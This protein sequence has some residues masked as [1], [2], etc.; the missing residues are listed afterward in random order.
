MYYAH[1]QRAL[2]MPACAREP[3]IIGQNLCGFDTLGLSKAKAFDLHNSISEPG[4]TENRTKAPQI[5]KKAKIVLDIPELVSHI[6]IERE[7]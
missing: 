5:P 2:V 7:A 6:R 4:S 1:S 3:E